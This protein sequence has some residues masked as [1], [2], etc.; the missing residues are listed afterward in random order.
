MPPPPRRFGATGRNYLNT[1]TGLSMSGGTG[2]CA[3]P[4]QGSS[5]NIGCFNGLNPDV[6]SMA[7][8]FDY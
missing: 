3:F 7:V 8:R 6:W 4:A 1:D 5:A 2:K